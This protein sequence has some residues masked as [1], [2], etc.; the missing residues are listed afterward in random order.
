MGNS[1]TKTTTTAPVAKVK[2]SSTKLGNLKSWVVVNVPHRICSIDQKKITLNCDIGSEELG[3][4]LFDRFK[5][6]LGAKRAFG[7][8]GFFL[9]SFP[10]MQTAVDLDSNEA[11]QFQYRNM[12]NKA[13]QGASAQTNDLWVFDVHTFQQ[14]GSE[15][16]LKIYSK[17]PKLSQELKYQLSSKLKEKGILIEIDY[18]G[19]KKH[20]IVTKI[21][22]TNINPIVL[23][24]NTNNLKA[25]NNSI[26]TTLLSL[27]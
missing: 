3:K 26:M 23:D 12:L 19:E 11:S 17:N 16:H 2:H 13:I 14:F 4:D 27:F 21:N 24:F 1:S 8:F 9:E 22:S 6:K 20:D 25:T 7:F 18:Q 5:G 15:P 10:N